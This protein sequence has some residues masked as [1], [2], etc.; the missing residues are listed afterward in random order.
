MNEECRHT[1]FNFGFCNDD[2]DGGGWGHIVCEG[3]GSSVGYIV[4]ELQTE[5]KQLKTA[6]QG[7]TTNSGDTLLKLLV[8]QNPNP[9]ELWGAVTKLVATPPEQSTDS[10]AGDFEEALDILLTGFRGGEQ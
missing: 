10:D 8:E 5:I 4:R 6:L 3:C 2:G 9:G 7:S 1:S